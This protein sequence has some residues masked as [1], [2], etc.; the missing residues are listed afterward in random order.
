MSSIRDKVKEIIIEQLGVDES[1]VTDEASFIDD[2]GA[3]SLD[4]VELVMSLEEKFGIDI[5]DE[6]A[7]KLDTVG[8]AIEYIES[9]GSVDDGRAFTRGVGGIG[10][11]VVPG[12]SLGLGD[13]L[14]GQSS[15]FDNSIQ[16]Q[17]LGGIYETSS[18][19][20]RD[21]YG[22]STRFEC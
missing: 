10:E 2:L 8:K 21:G 1:Q 7:E 6:E 9:K 22:E 17:D 12:V 15:G 20:H 13:L 4:T 11:G 3:D 16:S 18:R 5:S 14:P 19:S